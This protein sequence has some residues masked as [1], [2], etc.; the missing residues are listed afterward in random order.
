MTQSPSTRLLTARARIAAA[1]VLTALVLALDILHWGHPRSGWLFTAGFVLHGWMLIGAN[2]FFYVY[3]C[4]LGF[5]LRGTA[6]LERV[7]MLGWFAGFLLSPL[8]MLGTRWAVAI[9]HIGAAG[10][11]VALLAALSLLLGQS[12]EAESTGETDAR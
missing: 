1:L 3:L 9:K 2:V 8:N 11:A 6:G 7:L 12:N 10:L 5:W 4:W